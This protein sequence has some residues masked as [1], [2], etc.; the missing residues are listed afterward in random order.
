MVSIHSICGECLHRPCGTLIGARMEVRIHLPRPL[1]TLTI[2]AVG[3]LWWNGM[4]SFHWTD[5][6]QADAVGGIRSGAQIVEATQDIDRER[7]KQAVLG[8]QEEI[9]RY[10][11]EL[12][13]NEASTQPSAENQQALIDARRVL[14]GIIRERTQSEKLLILSLEQLWEAEGSA[15][16]TVHIVGGNGTLE[17]PVTP[18]LGISA[19]FEDAGY[20]KRFGL[21]HHAIDIPAQQGTLIKAPK[22][23]IVLKV[24]LNG[25]GYSYIVLAHDG[26]LQTVYGHI[27]AALV[28]E[29]DRVEVGQAIAKS[30]GQPGTAGAGLL[31]TGPHLHFAVKAG[32]VLVDPLQYLPTVGEE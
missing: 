30:G 22:E 6:Q 24:A 15:Y 16:S 12:L 1:L 18:A 11:V 3:L 2:V 9:L 21:A 32:G 14:L 8:R 23:G 25:L 27:S 20:K 31:T 17:W 26:D 5:T 19:M 4:L 10:Q 13:E 29:G 28:Q 7:V